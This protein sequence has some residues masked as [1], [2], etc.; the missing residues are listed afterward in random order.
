VRIFIFG[1]NGMLGNYVYSYFKTNT[2]YDILG[3]TR[4]DIDL[5]D[6]ASF[7]LLDDKFKAGDVII[8]CVGVIKQRDNADDIDFIIVNSV[9]PHY[10]QKVCKKTGAKLINIST[11]CVFSGSTG[12]YDEHS[13]HDAEDIYGKTKSIGEPVGSTTIRTSIIGEELNNFCSLIEWVKRSKDSTVLGYSNHF[14]NGITCLQFAKICK[15]IIENNL[16][17][18]GVQHIMSP[19][20][21]SKYRLVILISKVYGLNITVTPHTAP[22]FCDRA[23]SSV[24]GEFPLAIPELGIQIKEQKEYFK[25]IKETT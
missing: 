18:K 13:F 8:N 17:W 1:R 12:D 25:Y 21:L 7:K 16:F 10:L 20:K 6:I 4:K 9:F 5:S 3:I 19:K 11:D 14:W 23:L 24:K 22:K 15:Y 2:T